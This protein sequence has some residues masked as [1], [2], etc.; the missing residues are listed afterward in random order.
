M[1][2]QMGDNAE[3]TTNWIQANLLP[4]GE[5]AA[6]VAIEV[7]PARIATGDWLNRVHDG[8]QPVVKRRKWQRSGRQRKDQ[9][10]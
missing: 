10:L 5:L 7:G 8:C 6:A 9:L 2:A 3:K 4:I 1:C